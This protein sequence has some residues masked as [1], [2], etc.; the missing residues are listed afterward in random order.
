[1]VIQPKMPIMC[2][3]YKNASSKLKSVNQN[4]IE[5]V[6]PNKAKR[7]IIELLVSNPYG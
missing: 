3:N 4:Q 6:E 5:L 2:P 7:K 1:M